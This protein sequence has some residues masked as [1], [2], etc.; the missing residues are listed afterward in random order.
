MRVQRTVAVPVHD[1][2]LSL[3]DVAVSPAG[4][5]SVTVTGLPSVGCRL[6]LVPV[7]VSVLPTCPGAKVAGLC[8]AAI[9]IGERTNS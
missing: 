7:S 8:V 2:P 6:S 4:I 9:V 5:G 3:A 1:Q